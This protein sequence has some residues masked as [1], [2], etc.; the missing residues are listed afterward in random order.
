MTCTACAR[1]VE[2]NLNKVEGVSAYVDFASEKAHIK[3]SAKVSQERLR[4]AV[5]KAGYRVGSNRG[6][7]KTLQWRLWVGSIISLPVALISMIHELMPPNWHLIAAILTL[8]VALWVAWPFH[9]AA[10]KNLRLKTA[11]MDTLVSLGVIVS[12]GFSLVQLF[13][14]GMDSYFEV[15][16]VVPTVVLFGRWLEVRTRRSATDSVRA[17]LS[18]IPE[19]SQVRR[20]GL[21]QAVPTAQVKLGELVVVATGQ[22]IPLDGEIVE[23]KSQ[24]DNALITGESVPEEV[25]L[26]H[27][28]H[29]GSV[30]LGATLVIR[31]TAVSADSRISQIAD[32]VREATA[33]KTKIT[34]LTDKIS[35]IFVPAVIALALV[36]FIVWTFA[37]GDSNRGLSAAIAVLVIACP[38]ALGIAVPMSLVV[39]TSISAKRGIV[40]RNP[41]TL[42]LLNKVRKVVLDKTGTLTTGQ[43]RVANTYALAGANP[44]ELTAIAAAIERSSVHPIAKAIAALDTSLTATEVTETAGSGLQGTVTMA[45]NKSVTATVSKYTKDGFSNQ[46]ELDAAVLSAG[47]KTLVVVSNNQL[48]LL[49]FALEDDIRPESALAIKALKDL[50]IEPI[51]MSGDVSARVSFIAR[52]LEINVFYAE[53]TPEQKLAKITEIKADGVVTAMVGD[54]LND[55]AALAGADVGLAMGSGTHAAQSAAAI[56][57]VDDNPGAIAF[58][59][60][61]SRHTWVNIKQNLGWAFGYNVILIPVAA[62]G[63]LNPML[64]GSAMAF[65][66]VSVVANA[67]RL[68]LISQ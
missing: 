61:L 59:L 32:L 45:E 38:C 50:D 53:V 52:Q 39:A 15:A 17:L 68:K 58:A 21:Q 6:E 25:E 24:I 8:P 51:L 3:S 27:Q 35:E 5:E 57:I 7:L 2:K 37:I 40:I 48:A 64:A 29:A 62:L 49:L 43:L 46:N 12:Y 55:V 1:R 65:S 18:A 9:S 19:I 44:L 36:T 31:A 4:E 34:S 16:A 41:D 60:Q 13:T 33:H 22:R 11:T 54:G 10:F 20:D 67:L 28:L 30:N 42:G 14:A 23:G 66:S 26:G 47:A 63:L 56:T